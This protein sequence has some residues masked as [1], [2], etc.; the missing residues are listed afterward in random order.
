[1][2][3]GKDKRWERVDVRW[4]CCLP[5]YKCVFFVAVCVVVDIVVWLLQE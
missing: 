2:C 4:G 5:G 1:M 3:N